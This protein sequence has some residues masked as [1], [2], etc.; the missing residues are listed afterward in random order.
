MDA[1][2]RP[3]CLVTEIS[4]IPSSRWPERARIGRGKRLEVPGDVPASFTC[5]W[6]PA[7]RLLNR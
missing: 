7:S 4:N 2:R 6:A 1:L 3:A 5:W